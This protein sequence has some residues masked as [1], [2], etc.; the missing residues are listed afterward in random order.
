MTS[1]QINAAGCHGLFEVKIE[2]VL[3]VTFGLENQFFQGRKKEKKRHLQ[4]IPPTSV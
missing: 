1:E 3:R 4:S 2:S